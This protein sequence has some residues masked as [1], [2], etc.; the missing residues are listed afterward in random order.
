[1]LMT[2]K[3][4]ED[5][6]RLKINSHVM[7][8]RVTVKRDRGQYNIIKGDYIKT[9]KESEFPLLIEKV[10]ELNTEKQEVPNEPFIIEGTSWIGYKSS[11]GFDIYENGKIIQKG[12][13]ERDFKLY[14]DHHLAELKDKEAEKVKKNISKDYKNSRQKKGMYYFILFLSVVILSAV[15]ILGIKFGGITIRRDNE[16][17]YNTIQYIA[18]EKYPEKKMDKFS[19]VYYTLNYYAQGDNYLMIPKI[20]DSGKAVEI[21]SLLKYNHEKQGLSLDMSQDNTYSGHDFNLMFKDTNGKYVNK[22]ITY[23]YIGWILGED[24][25]TSLEELAAAYKRWDEND[26]KVNRAYNWEIVSADGSRDF[27]TRATYHQTYLM[28]NGFIKIFL[29]DPSKFIHEY[30]LFE[31]LGWLN[32]ASLAVL[33]LYIILVVS[34][35]IFKKDSLKTSKHLIR[36][37]VVLSLIIIVPL[38]LQ[39][40]FEGLNKAPARFLDVI[41]NT[42]FTTTTTVMNFLFNYIMKFS[43]ILLTGVVIIALPLKVI[44]YFILNTLNK[45]DPEKKVTKIIS[46][47]TIVTEKINRSNWRL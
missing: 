7:V 13:S 44:R 22:E 11:V 17:L 42:R 12:L 30:V 33:L 1:M 10:D 4:I 18:E 35:W 31:S 27:D 39:Y 40:F 16:T 37:I 36:L 46:P 24:N 32:W 15:Y 5:V 3:Q 38:T 47:D 6:K 43:N 26:N 19:A 23:T 20:L 21:N 8:G 2:K 29:N 9:Y 25:I 41:E 14:V 34:I 28:R 45:L